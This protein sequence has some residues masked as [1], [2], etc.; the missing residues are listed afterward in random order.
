L[1][2]AWLRATSQSRLLLLE[3]VF[4]PVT[5]LVDTDL[6]CDF[7]VSIAIVVSFDEA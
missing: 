7:A 4:S 3:L 2:F 6:V 1:T 5:E